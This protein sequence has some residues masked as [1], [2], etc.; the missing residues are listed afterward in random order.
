MKRKTHT[1]PNCQCASCKSHRGEHK[2]ENNPHFKHGKTFNNKCINCNCHI[3][4]Y[5]TRCSECWY[6]FNS[7]ENH[8]LWKKEHSI[9]TKKLMSKKAII[10][11]QNKDFKEKQLKLIFTKN[12]N[13]YT[14][15][16]TETQLE[17]LLN[18]LFPNKY[19][20]VGDG[21]TFI[22]GKCPDFIN[23]KDKRIIE[24]FGNYWHKKSEEKQRINHFK[25][26]GYNT[27]IIWEEELKNVD[28]LI[29]KL[30]SKGT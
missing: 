8:P 9:N 26:Y 3:T 13:R 1:N 23:F 15:N 24:L 30:N 27:L 17:I 25:K 18:K 28:K 16:R 21:Y 4:K 6:K 22:G 2:G 29:N 10:N 5:A 20:F 19:K 12:G 14:K 7:G 11:W